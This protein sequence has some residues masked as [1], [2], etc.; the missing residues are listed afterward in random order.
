ME[1]SFEFRIPYLLDVLD[2]HYHIISPNRK[3][4]KALTTTIEWY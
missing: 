1:D 3:L 4:G 2:G